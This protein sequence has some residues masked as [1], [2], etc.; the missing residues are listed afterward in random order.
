MLFYIFILDIETSMVFK[1]FSQF[2]SL[3]LPRFTLF[4][5]RISVTENYKRN[6]G[7]SKYINAHLNNAEGHL[8]NIASL[9]YT[10][11]LGVTVEICMYLAFF[12]PAS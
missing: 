2:F 7:I 8:R 12:E 9:C 1:I 4:F 11:C 3:H 10:S 5:M 6:T